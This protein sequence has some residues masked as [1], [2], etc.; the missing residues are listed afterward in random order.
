M[1]PEI[2]ILDKA[3]GLQNELHKFFEKVKEKKPESEYQDV[4]TIF[5]LMKIAEL[6]YDID[7]IR[8]RDIVFK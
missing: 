8:N 2:E 4:A 6:Q 5:I 7:Q 1:T 3:E